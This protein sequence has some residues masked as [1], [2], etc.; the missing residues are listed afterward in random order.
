MGMKAC[1]PGR[2]R[3]VFAFPFV[4][5]ATGMSS[6]TTE[7]VFVGLDYHSASVQVCAMASDGRVLMNESFANDWR[8]V[9]GAV[10]RH[11]GKGTRIQAAIESCCGAADLADELIG[12]GAWSVNL[13]HAGY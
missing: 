12:R 6:V 3:G 11:C 1:C 13:A 4:P 10:R 7:S 2:P 8:A 5:G 9:V